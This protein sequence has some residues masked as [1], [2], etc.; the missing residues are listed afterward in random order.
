MSGRDNAETRPE[1]PAVVAAVPGPGKVHVAGIDLAR[2]Q[3]PML[4]L[5]Q[6]RTPTVTGNTGTC[7]VRL[8]RQFTVTWR[9]VGRYE[10]L[11]TPLDGRNVVTFATM[12]PDAAM[13]GNL[14]DREA[15]LVDVYRLSR[16]I[17]NISILN[18]ILTVISGICRI[19]GSFTS[20]SIMWIL[21][22]QDVQ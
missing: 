7:Q 1:A 12:H 22:S 3:W 6:Y 9:L 8:A 2:F 20:V 10:S 4:S 14:T 18:V 17:R 15:E 19:S 11:N 16:F 21:W 13:M 5:M